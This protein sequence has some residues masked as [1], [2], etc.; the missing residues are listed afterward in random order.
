MTPAKPSGRRMYTYEMPHA[1]TIMAT[2]TAKPTAKCVP[3]L[4]LPWSKEAKEAMAERLAP[5]IDPLCWEVSCN[6]PKD[7]RVP[8]FDYRPECRERARAVLAALAKRGKR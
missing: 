2:I 5:L 4:V 6:P 1:G 7:A 3:V 8:W